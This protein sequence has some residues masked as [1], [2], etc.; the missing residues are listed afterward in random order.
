[1]SAAPPEAVVVGGGVAGLVAAFGLADRGYRVTLLESRQ[2]CGGRAFSTPDRVFDRAL[3][4]G[5][6]VMLGCY[7]A[8][9]AL[10]RRLGTEGGFQQDR[11]LQMRYRFVGGRATSLSLSRLPVP[12]PCRSKLTCCCRLRKRTGVGSRS[13]VKCQPPDGLHS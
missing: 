10:C 7:R 3:D 13:G 4:N 6:H 8:T 1:M 9:R 5:F 12:W 11:T 2:R